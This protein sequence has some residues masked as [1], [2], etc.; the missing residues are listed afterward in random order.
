MASLSQ[1]VLPQG[2]PQW[3]SRLLGYQEA[4]RA[5]A[6]LQ[7][8]DTEQPLL[9]RLLEF[10]EVT[11]KVAPADLNHIPRKGPAV[12][13]ANH[14]FGILEAAVIVTAISGESGTAKL[15]VL[16]QVILSLQL[17]F[18]VIPLVVF[19]SDRR[20]MGEFVSGFALKVTAWTVAVII[21]ALNAKLL[22]DFFGISALFSRMIS[23]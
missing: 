13:V 2:V 8:G 11:Y 6:A 10:L 19:T 7:H 12:I 15:L 3:L 14:P 18:A 9:K 4:D 22:A 23:K 20:K 5:Y 16:S 1:T 21:A 17:S